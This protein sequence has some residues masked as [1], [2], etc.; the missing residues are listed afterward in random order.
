MGR[1]LKKIKSFVGIR[2]KNF[3]WAV[4]SQT[5]WLALVWGGGWYLC[6]TIPATFYAYFGVESAE[7][8]LAIMTRYANLTKQLASLSNPTAFFSYMGAL[9]DQSKASLYLSTV[10][11]TADTGISVA[12]GLIYILGVLLTIWFVFRILK[13]YRLKMQ[14]YRTARSVT[15]KII[16]MLEKIDAEL[17]ALKSEIQTLRQQ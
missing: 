11:M 6:A 1:P 13:N 4:L 17:A 7:R 2:L 8:Q 16:P 12:T 10:R 9:F 14:E 15:Q 3:L 5:P